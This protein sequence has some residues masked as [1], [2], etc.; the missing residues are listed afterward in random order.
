M[1]NAKE[2]TSFPKLMRRMLADQGVAGFYRGIEANV[3]RACMLN[4]TK[5]S[6]YDQI[7]SIVSEQTGWQRKDL[8]C[9]FGS[10][11]GAG[12]LTAPEV[13][14]RVPVAIGLRRLKVQ[15]SVVQKVSR[16]QVQS[17]QYGR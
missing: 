16:L 7:K 15:S 14:W 2:K 1:A 13:Q 8:R 11:F 6:C 4:G 5:M 12:E 3:L 17:M 9:Q 10:A